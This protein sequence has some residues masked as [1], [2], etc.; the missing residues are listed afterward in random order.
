ME[1]HRKMITVQI[2]DEAVQIPYETPLSEIAEEY[3]NQRHE[4]P[5]LLARVNGKLRELHKTVRRDCKISFVSMQD[6]IG[7]KTY[8]RSMNLLFLKAIYHVAGREHLKKVV[9]HFAVDNGFYY[10][11]QGDVEIN[12]VLL[13]ETK[14]YMHKLVEKKIP[15]MKSN[16]S[17]QEAVDL[18][19]QYKMYDK[20]KLF[21][22][23][24]VSRV[25]IYNVDGFEDYFYGFMVNHTGYLQIFDLIHYKDGIVLLMPDKKQPDH[26]KPF[27][28]SEKVFMVQKEAEQWADKLDVSTVGDLNE[29]ISQGKMNQLFLVSEAL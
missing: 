24:R 25:N 12:E 27:H 19:H 28:P 9:L 17:T 21:K 11:L 8:Q 29:S 18:F 4:F 1:M 15:L 7:L 6:T 2:G 5:A 22:Y 26:I 3:Y 14:T 23:R 16:I 20:E 10:T 13:E